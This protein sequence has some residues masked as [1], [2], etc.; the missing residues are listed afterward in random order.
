MTDGYQDHLG[1]NHWTVSSVGQ[2]CDSVFRW[3][4]YTEGFIQEECYHVPEVVKVEFQATQNQL[5]WI[6]SR[7][8]ET[9]H[10]LASVEWELKCQWVMV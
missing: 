9:S 10:H 3:N 7:G 4:G 1:Y 6:A 8:H 5:A 2:V